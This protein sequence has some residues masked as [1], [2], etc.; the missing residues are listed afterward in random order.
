MTPRRGAR[1]SARWPRAIPAA[2]RTRPPSKLT[3]AAR[4]NSSRTP[5]SAGASRRG[6]RDRRRRSQRQPLPPSDGVAEEPLREHRQGHRAAGQHRLDQGD[7]GQR[8]RGDVGQ[9]GDRR[10]RPA[11]DEPARAREAP[12]SSPAGGGGRRAGSAGTPGASAARRGWSSARPPRPAL[13]RSRRPSPSRCRPSVRPRPCRAGRGCGAGVVWAWRGPPPGG[14]APRRRARARGPRL[15]PM[16][17]IS[18]VWSERTKLMPVPVRP[19]RP[20]RPTRCT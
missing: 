3:I 14:G 15:A 10:E 2:S 11:G 12:Q 8:E 13:S 20:V 6:S 17:R 9:P 18:S 19:A 7:R 5:G 4:E 16:R 1:R